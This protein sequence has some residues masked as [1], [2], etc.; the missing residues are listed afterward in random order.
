MERLDSLA[1]AVDTATGVEALNAPRSLTALVAEL[2]SAGPLFA[3]ELVPRLVMWLETAPAT[4]ANAQ[5]LVKLLDADAFGPWTDADGRPLKRTAL[6]ALLRFGYPWALHIKP[7]DLAWLRE[8]QRPFWRRNFKEIM[9]V[10]LWAG[11]VARVAW[12][13]WPWLSAWLTSAF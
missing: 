1:P 12:L 8:T 6:L 10:G 11:L 4:E 9:A 13:A 7:E 2:W 5:E 3:P